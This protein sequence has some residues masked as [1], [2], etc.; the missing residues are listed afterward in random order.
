MN[1]PGS[2]VEMKKAVRM[3]G[4]LLAIV[5]TNAIAQTS[6]SEV[7]TVEP[8]IIAASTPAP[9]Y[10]DPVYDGAA[11]PVLM[12]NP[13]ERVWW[14]FYTQRRAK[15]DVPGVEWCHGTE[16]GAA[17]SKDQ[18]LTWVYK[19]T[20]LLSHPDAGYSFWAPDVIRDDEGLFHIFVSYVPGAA[21][22]HRDWGGERH[23]LHYTAEDLWNW[24]FVKRIPLSSDYCIDATLIRKPGGWWRMWYKDEGQDSQTLAVESK[25]LKDWE[26]VDDPGVS[27]LYG[28]GPKAFHFKGRY[29][30]IKDPN[31][32]LDVY[33]S[34]DLENWVYQGKILDKPGTRNS[35]G[36]IGKHADVVVCGDRAYIIY[37]TH[38]YTENAA[39]R[40]GVSP[41]SNRHTALQAAEL[42]ILDG[43]LVCDRD[44]PFRLSLTPPREK[45]QG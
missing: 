22:T 43:K 21:D 25:D 24:K 44:K 30:L 10:R 33:C 26:P 14:M 9:L 19:G 1:K 41:L 32:G 13:G 36:A 17:E 2:M 18:G 38:P 39:A 16:I 20:L 7:K 37:F 11:D 5:F 34:D 45:R 4:V 15:I 8:K 3:M 40:N 31:S 12:W 28:E 6:R 35:D 23:I 42:E 27:K 29:W